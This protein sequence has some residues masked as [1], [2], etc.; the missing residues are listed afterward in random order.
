M[1]DLSPRVQRGMEVQEGASRCK[2]VLV[3]AGR[4]REVTEVQGDVGRCREVHGSAGVAMRCREE[5]GGEGG[6]GRHRE[7]EGGEERCR[8]AVM[9]RHVQECVERCD[10]VSAGRRRWKNVPGRC[11]EG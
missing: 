11:R 3:S 5:Q 6:A 9:Y 10:R 1:L 8:G 4:I 2:E 7:V